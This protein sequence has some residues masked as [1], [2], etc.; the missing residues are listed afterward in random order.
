MS[1]GLAVASGPLGCAS[2]RRWMPHRH[3]EPSKP[4]VYDLNRA[5]LRKI[6]TLPGITPSMAERIV[7]GRPY[8]SPQ[9]LVTRGILTERELKR[10]AD[11][12]RVGEKRD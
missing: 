1:L 6:K 9:D 4:P 12:V 3:R 7:E 10:I 8:E 5:P 2:V 11:R